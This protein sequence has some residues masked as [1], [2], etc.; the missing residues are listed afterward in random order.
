ME[1]D[2][3]PLVDPLIAQ[4]IERLAENLKSRALTLATA[5]SCTG[6]LVGAFCTSRPGSSE[7]FYGGVIAYDNSLKTGLLGVPGSTLAAYGAVSPET[8]AAMAAGARRVC[9]A[10]CAVS[11]TGVAGPDGGS[12]EK[13]VGLV[14]IGIATPGAPIAAHSE[15][16]P[17]SRGRIRHGAAG[18]AL[19]LLNMQLEQRTRP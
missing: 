1:I 9:G 5:E 14:V 2:F 15:I 19:E 13:P 11:L 12:P 7:W 4:L 8:A 17:G 6:G 16:F 18:R 3:A 10:D